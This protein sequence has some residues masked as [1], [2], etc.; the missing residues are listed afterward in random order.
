MSR[1]KVTSGADGQ[2]GVKSHSSV[3]HKPGE[4]HET[5]EG[6]EDKPRRGRRSVCVSSIMGSTTLHSN[7]YDD[8]VVFVSN[9]A[10]SE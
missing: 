3:L 1:C 10:F 2:S 5:L 8:K 4:D 6:E 7:V 9:L